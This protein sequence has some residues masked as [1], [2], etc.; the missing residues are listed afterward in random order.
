[1]EE[2]QEGIKLWGQMLT[3]VRFADDQAILAGTEVGLQKIM[4]KLNEASKRYGMRINAEKTKVMKISRGEREVINIDIILNDSII[5]QVDK[6][7]YL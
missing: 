4:N 1:M 5:E 7:K 6:F 2:V 3:D